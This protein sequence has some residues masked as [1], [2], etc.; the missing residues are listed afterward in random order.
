MSPLLAPLFRTEDAAALFSDLARVQAMLDVEAALARAQARLGIIPEKA[1]GP[2]TAA[3]RA[4]LY[5]AAALAH[6]AEL[7]G[8]LAIPMVKQLTARVAEAD[9]HAAGFVHWGATSQDIIDTGLILQL[10]CLLDLV[11]R[12]LPRLIRA[13]ASLAAQHRSTPMIGR[14]L[15]QQALPVTFGLKVA[16]WLDPLLRHRQRLAELR[17]RLLVVQL[18]GAAGTLA[19]L[20]EGGP[21]AA[22]ALA[23]ELGLVVPDMPWH[24]ARDRIVELGCWLGALTGSLGKIARDLSLM[25]QTELGEAREPAGEGRGGSSTMPHKRNPVSC[26]VVLAAATRAPGLVAAL[27][28]AMPQEHERGLGGWHAEWE[29]LPELAMLTAGAL[30]HLAAT[31]EGLELEPERMRTNIDATRGLVMAEAVQMALA[32]VLGRQEAHRLL[33]AASREAAASGR[34]LREILAGEPAV[35]DHLTATGLDDLFDPLRY[36]GATQSFID[37]VLARADQLQ[38]GQDAR[39]HHG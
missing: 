21:A 28:A 34:H 16:G 13:L 27:L 35:T 22:E 9:P 24:G 23:L 37:R 31:I 10:R 26:A 12:D 15:L 2:I 17:P 4:E 18:G 30:H 32:P 20:G 25:A 3:C 6:G 29:T 5:D 19:S 39:D 8:N 33:E 36:A 14:T 38:G 1:A 11:G 7:S